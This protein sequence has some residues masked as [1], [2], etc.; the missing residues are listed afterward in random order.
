MYGADTVKDARIAIA[1]AFTATWPAGHWEGMAAADKQYIG[2][3]SM[4]QAMLYLHRDENGNIDRRMVVKDCYVTR[5]SYGHVQHWYGDAANPRKRK[6]VEIKAME[7]YWNLPGSD[8]C[9]KLLHSEVD[10][11]GL[12]YRIYMAFSPHGTL[13]TLIQPPTKRPRGKGAPD[14]GL[15]SALPVP[16]PA[17]WCF[18]E[19]LTEACLLLE[20]GGVEEDE[21]R[22]G[23]E[24][25]VHRDIKL[26]NIFLAH[27]DDR[28][29]DKPHGVRWPAYPKPQLGDFG[30][31]IITSDGDEMNPTAYNDQEGTAGW[32]PQE[33]YPML[34]RETKYPLK[35][36]VLDQKTN[37]WGIGAVILRLMN[38]DSKPG[39]NG[40]DD[41]MYTDEDGLGEPRVVE[42]GEDGYSAE[43]RGLAR[44]CV[45]YETGLRPTLR[46]VRAEI[47]RCVGGVG[48]DGDWARGL[49]RQALGD[50]T[51]EFELR[52]QAD[53]YREQL[54]R[55]RL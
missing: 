41:N 52:Y 29:E 1:R 25:I 37:V 50:E 15:H 35:G 28:D 33:M 40:I 7:N 13:Q 12:F 10:G 43:L 3:G 24:R 47:L 2:G 38:R 5:I 6:H 45:R 9:V 32:M 49:R 34:D 54:A 48:E 53:E 17:L 20:F 16:E 30:I 36:S 19:A 23:W 42:G 46:E 44:W 27:P 39:T 21:A 18:F 31:A 55:P 51:R 4:G 22:P 11:D 26:Q 14:N 8:K